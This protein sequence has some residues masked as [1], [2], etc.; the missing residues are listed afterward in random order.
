MEDSQKHTDEEGEVL[1]VEDEDEETGDNETKPAKKNSITP[2]RSNEAEFFINLYGWCWYSD[3]GDQYI[4][5]GETQG[6]WHFDPK[7]CF[8]EAMSLKPNTE[9]LSDNTM[10]EKYK[11]DVFNRKD[12]VKINK[13]FLDACTGQTNQCK[14]GNVC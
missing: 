4:S 1:L 13:A 6:M 8:S 2:P 9:G 14:H 3:N 11:L 7:N 10:T 12:L 5:S